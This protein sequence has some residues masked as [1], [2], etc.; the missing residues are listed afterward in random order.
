MT[1]VPAVEGL[2]RQ[3]DDHEL[4]EGL[5]SASLAVTRRR[6]VPCVPEVAPAEA[7][8]HEEDGGEGPTRKRGQRV[9]DESRHVELP[10]SS[11]EPAEGEPERLDTRVIAAPDERPRRAEEDEAD[12]GGDVLVGYEHRAERDDHGDDRGDEQCFDERSWLSDTSNERRRSGDA[13]RRVRVLPRHV[14]L[15]LVAPPEI[16]GRG[17]DGSLILKTDAGGSTGPAS[18]RVV[19]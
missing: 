14:P 9:A 11:I 8:R 3:R 16:E 7:E 15:F 2:L 4:T 19:N 17:T 1:Q 6:N 13:L 18:L 5:F 12:D 10:G